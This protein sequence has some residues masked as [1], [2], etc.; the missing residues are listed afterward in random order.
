KRPIATTLVMVGILFFGVI[1]Y[2]GLPVS[3]L[4]TVDYPTINVNAGFPGASPETMAATVA[5]PLETAFASIPGIDQITS[6]SSQGSTNITLTFVLSR[7]IDAAAQD[8]QTAISR[9]V[10]QLPQGMPAPPS[11]NKSNPSDQPILFFAVQSQT[12]P[13]ST[14]N[15]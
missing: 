10:R 3:D 2:R 8:V 9:V 4:P 15:E 11:Y 6:S 12:L 14:V 1:G 5:T 13:L 7:G